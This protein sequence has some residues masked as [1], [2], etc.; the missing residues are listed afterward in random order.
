MSFNRPQLLSECECVGEHTHEGRNQ[1]RSNH[2]EAL[3]GPQQ[4][5][6]VDLLSLAQKGTTRSRATLVLQQS[7]CL[8]PARCTDWRDYFATRP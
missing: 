5:S 4:N 7:A 1:T 8:T 2:Q 3:V 6:A